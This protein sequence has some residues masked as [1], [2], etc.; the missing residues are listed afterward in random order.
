VSDH[1]ASEAGLIASLPVDDPERQAAVRH[2]ENCSSCRRALAES[3]ELMRLLD[4][5]REVEELPL[6]TLESTARAIEAE[7]RSEAR[8]KMLWPGALV[9]AAFVLEVSI[10]RHL[11]TDPRA[12]GEALVVA[13]VAVLV[14]GWNRSGLARVIV[15]L[16]ASAAFALAMG[17]VPLLAPGLGVKCMALEL[18]AAAIPWVGFRRVTGVGGT[19][20]E[21]AAVAA[22]GALAGHAALHLSCR[23]PNASAH[24]LVFHVGGVVLAAAL[25]ALLT[26]GPS[27]AL[28]GV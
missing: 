4:T 9:L 5:A 23:V 15:S 26:P 6:G 18:V 16:S 28:R 19:K 12:I 21:G 27:K 11:R 2:A 24:L 1:F 7:L 8:R 25:G 22:A 14:G 13:A 3:L 17:S 10:S 20:W